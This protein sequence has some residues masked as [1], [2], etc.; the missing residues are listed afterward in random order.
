MWDFTSPDIVY[1]EDALSRLADVPG[2]RAFILTDVTLVELGY[3][4]LVEEYL[5]VNEIATRSFSQIEPEPSIDTVQLARQAIIDFAPDIVIALGGGSVMDVA[6]VSWLMYEQPGI[7][8]EEISIFTSYETG[9]SLLIT[10]PTT[11]GSG[12]DM[13]PGVVLT[14]RQQGRKVVLYAREFQPNLTI[15][16]PGLVMRVPAQVTA[17]T[18]MDVIS[19]AVEAFASPWHNDFSDGLA[20]KAL[21][22]AFEYLPL[23]YTDGSD[24]KAREHMHN[25]ATISGLAMANSSISLGHALAHAFGG[26]FPIPHGRIVGMF[27]PYSMEFSANGGG[28][29]YKKLAKFLGLSSANEQEGLKELVNAIRKLAHKI[30]QPLSISQMGIEADDLERV[31][32]DLIEKAATDHQML[33][34]LRVP[35]E[36]ELAQLYQYAYSGKT[37]DF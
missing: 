36:A 32:P 13:T 20:V 18:G 6:K 35:D 22:L 12:A 30:D 23:A 3:L 4:R 24:G 9:K 1:G 14:D 8:L 11:S 31:M 7:V 10:I 17:D 16:D 25:A 26:L 37:I 2:F 28:S 5:S 29:R 33:T 34:T 27:L 21:Q 19:H 15:V